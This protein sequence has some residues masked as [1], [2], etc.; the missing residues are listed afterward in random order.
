MIVCG[1]LRT[2]RIVPSWL[3][4]LLQRLA[5]FPIALGGIW[6]GAWYLGKS[7]LLD[8][9]RCAIHSEQR[10]A[11]AELSP[12][13]SVTQEVVVCDRD[14]L[15]AATPAGAFQMMVKWLSVMFDQD[16]ADGV[17]ALLDYDQSRFA[18]FVPLEKR[19]VSTPMQEV[20]TLMEANLE[21]PLESD[22]LAASVG[23]SIRQIQRL[24]REELNTT[25]QK[26]Y[27]YL[28]ISAARRLIQNSRLAMVDVALACGF[29]SQPHFSRCYSSLV[30]HPPSKEIRFEI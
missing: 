10:I 15:T 3:T 23:L 6:N 30:G 18:R 11:L 14:R 27:L 19:P 16:L 4:S 28:R 7:G 17:V 22:Q 29:V 8:G 2:S 12:N 26:H 5:R 13:A 24:F 9:Y 20:V 25:P 21:D 1:G